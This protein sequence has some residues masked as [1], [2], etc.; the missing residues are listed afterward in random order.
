VHTI[1]NETCRY[2][3]ACRQQI[4]QSVP[5]HH[6]LG[7]ATLVRKQAQRVSV[8]LPLLLAA[9][10]ALLREVAALFARLGRNA[11][12]LVLSNH[13]QS[14]LLVANIILIR[15]ASRK[16]QRARFVMAVRTVRDLKSKEDVEFL[17][18]ALPAWVQFTEWERAEVFQTA[19][20]MLWPSL[21]SWLCEVIKHELEERL[22]GGDGTPALTFSRLSFGRHPPV[23][24]GIKAASRQA[25][26]ML[27]M[28]VDVDVRWAGK[29]LRRKEGRKE[30]RRTSII[31]S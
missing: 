23:V 24:A 15:T 2:T 12:I 30:R 11:G 22:Q 13:I 5:T 4:L 26:D 31:I 19:I 8:M 7:E 1:R 16:L 25:G 17:L 10:A 6:A 29:K 27:A 3:S 21:N 9:A 14:V 18:G 20:T 28:V